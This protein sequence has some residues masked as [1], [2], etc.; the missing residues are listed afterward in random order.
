MYETDCKCEKRYK[1]RKCGGN[2]INPVCIGGEDR[3][4]QY[5]CDKCGETT[6]LT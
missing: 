4:I 1:G 5:T 3:E 6:E 2:L